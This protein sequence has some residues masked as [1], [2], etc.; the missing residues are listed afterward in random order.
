VEGLVDLE[1]LLLRLV[2]DLA[3]FGV[4]LTFFLSALVFLGVLDFVKVL[5]ALL[6]VVLT[7]ISLLPLRCL[8]IDVDLVLK[9]DSS[10]LALE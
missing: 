1:D 6:D 3:D 4:L 8:S 7:G 2:F 9:G 10:T 5:L